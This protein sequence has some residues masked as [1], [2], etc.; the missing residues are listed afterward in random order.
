MQRRQEKALKKQ[1]REIER[2]RKR[3]CRTAAPIKI[4][5]AIA[6]TRTRPWNKIL[7]RYVIIS[8]ETSRH[9]QRFKY[10][11]REK[12]VFKIL[13]SEK[14]VSKILLD[15]NRNAKRDRNTEVL[16]PTPLKRIS[17]RDSKLEP[18]KGK[19]DYIP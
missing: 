15:L 18:E 12:L 1:A 19:H 6:H 10:T 7:K 17:S 3:T 11:W 2:K 13:K 4:S 14:I 16:Q 9:K 5:Y 8:R